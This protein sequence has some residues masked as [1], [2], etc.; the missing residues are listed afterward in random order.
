METKTFYSE[1][2]L[3]FWP[4]PTGG[5]R[6]LMNNGS[7]V[8]VTDRPI[9]FARVGAT[10]FYSYTTSN[11]DHIAELEARVV[12]PGDVLSAEEFNRRLTPDDKKISALESKLRELE[13]KNS[14]LEK[15]QAQG[16][17]PVK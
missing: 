15:L 5:V 16:K 17:L 3:K 13:Q 7:V 11:P 6:E 8:V 14:L 2:G 1:F 9:H 4:G 10:N 12:S